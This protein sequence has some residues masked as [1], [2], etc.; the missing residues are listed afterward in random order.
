M[1]KAEFRSASTLLRR[2]KPLKKGLKKF[3]GDNIKI[4]IAY[5]SEYYGNFE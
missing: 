4:F 5:F 2:M 3:K 1:L